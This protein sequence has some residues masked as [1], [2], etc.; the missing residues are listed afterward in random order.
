MNMT[1]TR[2]QIFKYIPIVN[3]A[4]LLVLLFIPPRDG[5][6]LNI[7]YFG[8]SKLGDD[9]VAIIMLILLSVYTALKTDSNQTFFNQI[10]ILIFTSSITLVYLF[11]DVSQVN[12]VYLFGLLLVLVFFI[13][14][15]YLQGF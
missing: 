6:E 4:I 12:P 2:L 14:N 15:I 5:F 9:S 1:N 8:I 13:I 10:S 7:T 3:A 11:A